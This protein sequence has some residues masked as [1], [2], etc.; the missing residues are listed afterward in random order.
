[1]YIP[2]RIYYIIYYYHIICNDTSL[3][4]S[5]INKEVNNDNNNNPKLFKSFFSNVSKSRNFKPSA[6]IDDFFYTSF[7]TI[8]SLNFYFYT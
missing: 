8:K 6:D 5:F 1:M 3:C 7:G 2:T 4:I